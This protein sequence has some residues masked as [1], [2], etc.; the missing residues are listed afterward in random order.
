MSGKNGRRAAKTSGTKVGGSNGHG[1][2]KKGAGRRALYLGAGM[3]ILFALGGAVGVYIGVRLDI[4]PEPAGNTQLSAGEK[5]EVGASDVKSSTTKP[6]IAFD[7]SRL[8]P[9]PNV[10]VRASR[11]AEETDKYLYEESPPPDIVV[12]PDAGMAVPPASNAPDE[13]PGP[14]VVPQQTPAQEEAWRRNAVAV[15]WHGNGPAIA[16][17]IDD[18]GVDQKRSA[19]AIALPGPMTMSFLPYGYHLKKFVETAH[20]DGHEI[21]VHMPMEPSN[22]DVNPGPNALL[23]ELPAEE[24][25]KRVIWNLDQFSGYVGVNN[26]MGS[27]FT[28]NTDDMRLVLDMLKARGLLFVDSYTGHD[29]QGYRVAEEIGMPYAIRDIF[30]D[31]QQTDEFVERQLAKTEALARKKGFAIAIG[32]PHDVTIKALSKWLPTLQAK[33]ISLVPVSAIISMKPSKS[34]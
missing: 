8:P 17:I 15:N 24:L 33:G 1:R 19:E 5:G 29:T 34:G 6:A 13:M 21:M 12:S 14:G 22:P 10:G 27:L 25:Q 31:H 26:H 18:L 9:I 16:I 20:K 4:G 3:L 7:T 30:L 11:S 2:R 23:T 28:A 32:H